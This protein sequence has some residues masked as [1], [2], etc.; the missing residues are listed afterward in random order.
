MNVKEYLK[1]DRQWPR[2]HRLNHARWQ[3]RNAKTND[4]K[5]FWKAVVK[6]NTL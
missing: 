6:A 2:I 1:A 5:E 4:E 3:L